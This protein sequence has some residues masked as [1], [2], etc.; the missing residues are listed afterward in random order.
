MDLV[1]EVDNGILHKYEKKSDAD[2]AKGMVLE[3]LFGSLARKLTTALFVFAG[4]LF[5]GN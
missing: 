3:Y 5:W 4:Y 2:I 1:E